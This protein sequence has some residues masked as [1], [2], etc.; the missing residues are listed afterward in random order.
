MTPIVTYKRYTPENWPVNYNLPGFENFDV[1]DNS[2]WF[3]VSTH[4]NDL[5]YW[6]QKT[7]LVFDSI[8]PLRAGVWFGSGSN[9]FQVPFLPLLWCFENSAPATK[10]HVF[11]VNKTRA[12]ILLDFLRAFQKFSVSP[13]GFIQKISAQPILEEFTDFYSIKS[14]DVSKG[15]SYA[16][17]D[18]YVKNGRLPETILGDYVGDP[19]LPAPIFESDELGVKCPAWVAISFFTIP[20]VASI[21]LT[22]N[23]PRFLNDYEYQRF[24]A[25][26]WYAV[27]RHTGMFNVAWS[28]NG[29]RAEF[30]GASVY[31]ERPASLDEFINDGAGYQHTWLP[32]IPKNIAQKVGAFYGAEL[33]RL[34][35][36]KN[37][38]ERKNAFFEFIG[39][40]SLF[41]GLPNLFASVGS[42]FAGEISFSNVFNAVK[43]A[44][45]LGIV[46]A[47][48]L[49]AVGNL[50][51]A[52]YTISQPVIDSLVPV[53]FSESTA[54]DPVNVVE[55]TPPNLELS[56]V[57]NI[58]WDAFIQDQAALEAAAGWSDLIYDEIGAFDWSSVDWGAVTDFALEPVDLGAFGADVESW[59]LDVAA[60]VPGMTAEQLAAV[61]NL[62]EASRVEALNAINEAQQVAT[63]TGGD[64]LSFLNTAVKNIQGSAGAFLTLYTTYKKAEQ[65]I[66][67]G[68]K[69][70]APIRN[71]T[72][73][74]A[75]GQIVRQPDGSISTMLPDGSIRTVRPDGTSIVTAPGAEMPGF[76]KTGLIIGG[77]ALA[78][79]VLVYLATSKRGK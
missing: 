73:P 39:M 79:G 29:A 22:D 49:I 11:S 48:K 4:V 16:L 15:L 40:A 13:E 18:F 44:D 58:D 72:R 14:V 71:A 70:P 62:N 54:L 26:F 21:V 57:D 53:N 78:A 67:S 43:L 31:I 38:A 41:L 63:A 24:R 12:T 52:F 5:D 36:E 8:L 68:G 64:F 33:R 23:G 75:P 74:T 35:E 30:V 66:S 2:A 19:R 3:G 25:A 42:L 20:N 32:P 17:N 60:N 1:P 51:D 28:L 50:G 6:S 47:D 37:K 61:N 59:G 76:T 69:A 65:V 9:L 56:T 77:A 45:K 7:G 27:A 55:Y 10:E 46:E 34:S